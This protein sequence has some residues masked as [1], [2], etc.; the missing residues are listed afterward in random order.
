MNYTVVPCAGLIS[1]KIWK[2]APISGTEMTVV[3]PLYK[4][5]IKG[6]IKLTVLR[7]YPGF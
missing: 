6:E 3:E 2:T 7:I 5:C 4:K 1:D